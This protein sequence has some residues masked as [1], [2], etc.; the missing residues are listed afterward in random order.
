MPL[1]LRELFNTFTSF[2]AINRR[3]FTLREINQLQ[4]MPEAGFLGKTGV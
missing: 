3:Y 1:L 2:W 4:G